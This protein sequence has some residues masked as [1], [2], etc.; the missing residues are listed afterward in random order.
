[1]REQL[2]KIDIIKKL[3]AKSFYNLKKA[4]QVL[5]WKDCYQFN[6]KAATENDKG[7][8]WWSFNGNSQHKSGAIF[9]STEEAEADAFIH[10][11]CHMGTEVF[12]EE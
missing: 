5:E 12:G 9:D 8:T 6:T 7:G 11:C 3:T 10:W 1:M 2:N 4:L